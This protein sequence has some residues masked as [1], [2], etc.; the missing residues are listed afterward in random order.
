MMARRHLYGD[1]RSTHTGRET[2]RVPDC[3]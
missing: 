3:R 1:A 2:V